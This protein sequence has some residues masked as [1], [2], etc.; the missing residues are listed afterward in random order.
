MGVISKTVDLVLKRPFVLIYTGIVV[1][2]LLAINIYNPVLPLLLGLTSITKSSV[3]ESLVAA[4]QIISDPKF[5]P[6]L[7][8]A[9]AGGVI[10]AS[11]VGSAVVSGFMF[12]LD[13][14][15]ENLPSEKGEFISG[16]KKY[17]VRIILVNLRTI[18]LTVVFTIFIMVC[19]V[20]AIVITKSSFSDKPELLAASIL[21]DI[22]T[23]LV[24]ILGMLFY[25][26]YILFWYPAVY[27]NTEKAFAAGKKAVDKGF[28]KIA[29]N[30][31][32]FGFVFIVLQYLIFIMPGSVL[33]FIAL[34]ILWTAFLLNL[35]VFVFATY[36]EYSADIFEAYQKERH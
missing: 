23:V 4:L 34:W 27:K 11:V 12:K 17:F 31:L 19:S 22:L 33:K 28:W 2:V 26:S 9:V 10:I 24:V 3:F 20:P 32:V 36:R 8:L 14:A 18:F 6:M 1:A 7:V 25:S 21:V 16:L 15:V 5:L 30:L 35:F 29:G 13:R